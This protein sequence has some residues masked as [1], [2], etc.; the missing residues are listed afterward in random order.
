MPNQS[1]LVIVL[2]YRGQ[3]VL[4]PCLASLLPTLGP[5]DTCLVVDNGGEPA[6]MDLVRQQLPTVRILSTGVNLG[7]ARGMNVGL[8]IAHEEGFEA[9]W[10][11][12]NDVRVEPGALAALKRAQRDAV[13]RNIFSPVILNKDGQIWFAGGRINYWRMRVEHRRD[14]P[15]EMTP[16]STQFLT[17]C[18]L[19][20][21]RE[22]WETIGFLDERYFL[23]YEDAEYS[24]RAQVHGG[25]LWVVP[26]A[27]V[28]HAEVS[29]AHPEKVYWLV[30][31]G[32]EFFSRHT[33]GWRRSWVRVYLIARRSKNFLER[34]F[35]GT[36]LAHSIKRAYTDASIK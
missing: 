15:K 29:E 16:F 14:A 10:L 28:K 35:L 18:A 30:R 31:S 8:R 20:I 3:D 7:F 19:F 4:L 24:V 21:P 6:L 34:L 23:Y 2:N 32:V 13:G 36:A 33:V 27:R 9:A 25:K 22:T 11:L 1:V 5:Q 12:N 17:G 26:E